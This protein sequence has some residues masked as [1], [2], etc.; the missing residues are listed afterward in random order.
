MIIGL[1]L[2]SL[3][4]FQTFQPVNECACA[5]GR[6]S[7]C[8]QTSDC[9]ADTWNWPIKSA[10][11]WWSRDWWETPVRWSPPVGCNSGSELAAHDPMKLH[12]HQDAARQKS[13]WKLPDSYST[14]ESLSWFCIY[15]TSQSG[16]SRGVNRV[17]T[18]AG[19]PSLCAGECID[20][21]FPVSIPLITPPKPPWPPL[22]NFWISPWKQCGGSPPNLQ[23]SKYIFSVNC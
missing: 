23:H 8:L 2:R 22:S 14:Y 6:S 4:Y 21:N 19:A 5:C 3:R 20:L 15:Q 13:C 9:H 1:L 17:V 16:G 10:V 7:A 11:V 18:L 12:L